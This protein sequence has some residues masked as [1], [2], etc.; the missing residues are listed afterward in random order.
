MIK[1]LV[2]VN[3]PRFIRV[4][5]IVPYSQKAEGAFPYPLLNCFSHDRSINMLHDAELPWL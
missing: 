4:L 1:I 3:S 5:S 2:L